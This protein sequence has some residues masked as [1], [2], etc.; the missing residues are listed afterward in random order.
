M[1]FSMSS[2]S[3][4]SDAELAAFVAGELGSRGTERVAAHLE[5]CP[6]CPARLEA[7]EAQPDEMQQAIRRST[8]TGSISDNPSDKNAQLPLTADAVPAGSAT[9]SKGD[10]PYA[11]V[12]FDWPQ[13][14][15]AE[16]A[17]EG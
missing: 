13:T 8:R 4:P 9:P 12:A 10:T 14:V 15:R 5:E 11:P 16:D 17:A 6:T 2:N 7:L 1:G 3:C